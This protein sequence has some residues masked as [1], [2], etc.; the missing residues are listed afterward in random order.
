M[1]QMLSE[2][3]TLELVMPGIARPDF[4]RKREVIRQSSLSSH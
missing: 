3:E 1:A 4:P 2:K